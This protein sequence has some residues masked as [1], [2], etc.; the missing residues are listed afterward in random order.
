MNRLGRILIIY[1]KELVDA[2][3]DKRTLGAMLVVPVVLYPVLMLVVLQALQI[4]QA[5]LERQRYAVAVPDRAHLAWL[6]SILAAE[7]QRG[8]S[9]P[10]A[11]QKS[12]GRRLHAQVD[13]EHFDVRICT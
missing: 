3:R 5:K 6:T 8:A 11:T 12:V 13:P 2:L 4:E 1:R 9:Q 10:A 7:E